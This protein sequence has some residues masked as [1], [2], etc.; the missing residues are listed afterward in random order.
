MSDAVSA[1]VISVNL[2][3]PPLLVIRAW[4]TAVV[5]QIVNETLCIIPV[6]SPWIL[7][8][9]QIRFMQIVTGIAGVERGSL[10]WQNS[11]KWGNCIHSFHT[12]CSLMSRNKY[13]VI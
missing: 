11:V 2:T 6:R 7:V 10:K 1:L 9:G 13:E 12:C 8:S 3:P 4:N 5:P